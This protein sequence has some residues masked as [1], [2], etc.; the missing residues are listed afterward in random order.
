MSLDILIP[1]LERQNAEVIAQ[2]LRNILD[3]SG[4]TDLGVSHLYASL[5]GLCCKAFGKDPE[6]A[7]GITSA[8]EVLYLAAQLSDTVA[9]EGESVSDPGLLVTLSAACI[10]IGRM[11]LQEQT[12]PGLSVEKCSDILQDFDRAI[13]RV[14]IGQVKDL[15]EKEPSL[16]KCWEIAAEKTGEIFALAARSVARLCSENPGVIALFS[17]LGQHLGL[18]VQIGDDVKGLWPQDHIRSDLSSGKWTLP[19]SYAMQVMPA[20]QR[21]KLK[22]YL[23]LAAR[24]R[25]ME[26]AARKM[27]IEAGALMYLA[28]EADRHRQCALKAL[29]E[30]IPSEIKHQELMDFINQSTAWISG[31]DSQVS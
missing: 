11:L 24:D 18:L 28:A 8:W 10:P 12:R 7:E 17:D 13:L 23:G 6:A 3:F 29:V 30:A 19:V 31:D 14:C 2:A 27:L 4:E 1:F 20:A 21:V 25:T 9:D 5:P 26:V 16:E 15:T 22:G